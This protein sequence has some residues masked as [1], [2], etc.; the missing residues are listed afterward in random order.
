MG[1]RMFFL[2]A[3]AAL[4]A[5]TH[6]QEADTVATLHTLESIVVT[7]DR[8]ASVLGRSA[9]SVSVMSGDVLRSLPG[10]S[11]LA[12]VLRQ[13]PG[14][15]ILNL[16]GQGLDPQAVVRGFYGGGETEYV[17]VLLDGRPINNMEMG[18]VNWSQIPLAA[19]ESVEVIRGGASSLYGDAAVGG[20]LNVVTRDLSATGESAQLSFTTGSF[21]TYQAEASVRTMVQGLPVNVF[22]SYLKTSGF[23]A[24]ASRVASSVG[25]TLDLTEGVSGLDASVSA[26][27][28]LRRYDVPGPL[29][30]GELTGSRVQESPF[31]RFD[32]TDEASLRLSSDVRRVLSS[33]LSLV[34]AASAEWRR[35]DIVRTLPL[36]A[37]F[38]DTKSRELRTDRYFVS[39]QVVKERLMMRTDKLVA[40]LEGSFGALDNTYYNMLT[41]GASDYAAFSGERGGVSTRGDGHR[42]AMAGFVQYD[43]EPLPRVRLIAGGRYDAIVDTY[44]PADAPGHRASHKAFSPKVGVNVAFARSEHH[45]GHLYANYLGIFKAATLDQLFDQRLL[46]VPFPPFAIT[47]SNADLKPQRGTSVELGGYQ[48][49]TI[50]RNVVGELT[51]AAYQVDMKDEL[52]FSFETLSYANIAS[53][54]HTGIEGGLRLAAGQG[55]SAYA[56]YTLQ[57]VTYEEGDYRGNYVKGIPR[58]YFNMGA[59]AALGR[60]LQLGAV[61]H[62]T[63]RIFLDDANSEPLKSYTTLDASVMW[64]WRSTQLRLEAT[65]VLD[66]TYST[67]G[68][69]DPDPS[70]ESGIVFLYPAAGRAL[71]LGLSVS[72]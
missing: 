24:H 23:R 18:L 58:D 72:L 3:L 2:L 52:D 29:T 46:P 32:N 67:T 12:D 25:V 9:A 45:T 21:R 26:L 51:L 30:R 13:M 65:N 16:D 66:A 33:T 48:L 56:N 4:V 49:W 10:V 38:A 14:F 59:S 35:A 19:I 54:R 44:N 17:L 40:G 37:V 31:F 70:S 61:L 15:A 39:A 42:N 55:F 5:N 64:A 53:S 63:A 57:N 28:H 68:F 22:G 47:I 71:R 1:S 6:A 27:G 43:F 62:S 8:S 11:R 41:G 20:V 34:A 60:G 7:A 36:A 50:T 69:P